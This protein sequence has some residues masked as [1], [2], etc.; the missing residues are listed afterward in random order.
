MNHWRSSHTRAERETQTSFVLRLRIVVI[1]MYIGGFFMIG[2]LF[3]LMV[4]HHKGYTA[5]ASGVQETTRELLPDRGRIFIQN[6]QTGERFPLAMNRDYFLLFAD[7]RVIQSDEQAED[8]AERLA[9]V[10]QYNDEKKFSVYTQLNKRTDPYEPIEKK[11]DEETMRR[12]MDKKLP[13][14]HAVGIPHRY[15]P[16]GSLAA[17]VIGFVGKDEKGKS[18]G[19]YGIEGY[20]DRELAGSGGFLEGV[21]SADGYIIPAEG[22]LFTS[23][24]PPEDGASITL[25]LDRSIQFVACEKLRQLRE[26]YK[27]ASG[28]LVVMDAKTGAIRALCSEP[29]FDPNT[30]AD[31]P[32]VDVYNNTAIFTPYEPGSIFKPIAMAAALNESIVTPETP[33]VDPGSKSGVCTKPIMNADKKIYGAQ[34]MTGILE[35]S[36]NTGMVYVVEQVGKKKFREYVE[37]FGFGVKEGIEIDTEQTGT[38]QSLSENKDDRIDCYTATAS[39]GQGIT[40]TPLQMAAAYGAIANGGK[41]MRPYIVEEIAYPDGKIER[42]RPT[43]IRQVMSGRTSALL[44]GMLVNVIE[45]GFSKLARVEGYRIAGK[46]GT[47]QIAGPGGYNPNETIHSF[48]GFGPVED[49]VFV[50]IIKIEKPQTE[51]YSSITIAPVFRE[52]AD[53]ILSYYSVPPS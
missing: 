10:F 12:I 47:A 44:S 22:K 50:L 52:I 48:M 51:Q 49:P 31:A 8:V 46:S 5:L 40:V 19:R 53:F 26:Y 24:E 3:V 36:I 34:T 1:G 25:T 28:A 14:I 6:T 37:R 38:I 27:A 43:E 21:R 11:I 29:G 32:S 9:E 18:A 13:G 15:Y 41:L 35:K 23:F 39:F 20:F 45:Q 4:L 17:H 7:T 30:Y 42:R 16:E 2:Q 33:F